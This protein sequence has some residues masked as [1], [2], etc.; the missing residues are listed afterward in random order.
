MAASICEYTKKILWNFLVQDHKVTDQIILPRQFKVRTP[1]TVW[2]RY[3][4]REKLFSEQIATEIISQS[5]IAVERKLQVK[6]KWYVWN[7]IWK[8]MVMQLL[9]IF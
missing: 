9:K 5:L 4:F 8:N 3:S 6:F 2:E 1:K 7:L